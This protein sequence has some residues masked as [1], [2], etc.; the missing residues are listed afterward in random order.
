MPKKPSVAIVGA[1]NLAT[2]LARALR[3]AGYDL[4][5]VIFRPG[6]GSKSRAESLARQVSAS[7]R[8]M[9]KASLDAEIVWLCVPDGQIAKVALE[10]SGVGNWKGKV[11]LHSSGALTSGELASLRKRG[12]AGASVHPLMTFVR[13]SAA[14]L[15]G[16]PFA[17][18]GD[19][20]AVRAATKVVKDFEGEAFLIASR[21]K[22]AHH[23]WGAF[24]SPLIIAT[25]AIAEQVGRL[26]GQSKTSARRR[27]L[28]IVKQTIRNYEALGAAE[29]FSGPIVRGD[30][31]TLRRHVQALS[32]L[33]E[34]RAAYLVLARS[35]IRSLP[36]R[37]RAALKKALGS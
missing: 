34:A 18:E 5:E 6:K 16:V 7:A 32:D 2:A 37:N 27:M 25:L 20:R 23:A 8:L 17:I 30:A 35:A 26:A 33:P 31:D 22:A 4:R 11:V 36:A 15:A 24:T 13:K 14:A 12:A 28:P 19:A 3:A 10:L 21:H 29:S 1:G 9:A